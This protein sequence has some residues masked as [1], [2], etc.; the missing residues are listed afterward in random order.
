M[1][2][3]SNLSITTGWDASDELS[4]FNRNKAGVSYYIPVVGPTQ[5]WDMLNSQTGVASGSNPYSY[6]RIGISSLGA[7]AVGTRP[8]LSPLLVSPKV[9]LQGPV[10][11]GTGIMLDG[12]RTKTVVSGGTTDA[13]HGVIP[14]SDPYTGL[15]GFTHSGSGGL[16]TITPGVFGVFN[17]TN[18]DAIVDWVFVSI[19]DGIT[20]TV[21]STRAALIQRDGDVV[22]TDG[23]SPVNMAGNIAANYFVSVRHRNHLG[24]R[25]A[26]NMAL[27]KTTTTAY[28]FSSAQAQAYQ[29]P[30]ILANPA[31]NNNPA[32]KDLGSSRF[33]LWG[34]NSNSNNNVRFTGLQ[35][36]AG[37]IITALGGQQGNTLNPA[38]HTSDL[39]MDGTVKYTGLNN[40]AGVLLTILSGI[41]SAV[42]TQHL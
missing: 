38:Y 6:T 23:V 10:N 7:F 41:Q 22:E 14:I 5:G 34:G 3:G 28:N 32:M 33:S 21:L 29:N 12:L 15:S 20:G 36:D 8:V 1:A 13:T 25:S 18:D 27:A 11:T 42:Y 35:N 17:I 37:V 9:I 19:H 2:G 30:A 16:E 40:D 39:N 31:P 24:V 4:G 26:A